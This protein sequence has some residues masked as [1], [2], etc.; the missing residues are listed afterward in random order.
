MGFAVRLLPSVGKLSREVRCVPADAF[1]PIV[2]M[3]GGIYRKGCGIIGEVLG[4]GGGKM[5][6]VAGLPM[7]GRS[8]VGGWMD[9]YYIVDGLHRKLWYRSSV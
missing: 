5:D 3:C 2:G 7:A 9:G 6:G 4:L 8:A 1:P